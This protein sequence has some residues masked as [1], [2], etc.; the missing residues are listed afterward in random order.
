MRIVLLHSPLVGPTTWTAVA[1]LL[2]HTGYQVVVPDLRVAVTGR[3][4]YQPAIWR[5]VTD[6]LDRA[7]DGGS[8]VLVG[9]SGAGQLLPAIASACEAAV[10]ALVFVDAGMPQPGT[11]WFQRVPDDLAEHIR[12]L[13]IGGSLPS[14]DQWFE[15]GAIESL[16]PEP[17]AR[18]QFRQDLPRVPLTFLAEPTPLASWHGPCGYLLLSEAYRSDAEEAHRDGWPVVEYQS[19]HLAMLT[20]PA[21]VADRL[22]GLIS[23]LLDRGRPGQER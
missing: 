15:P 23:S 9:H 7:N 16:L 10:P 20:E 1:S 4:P 17:T 2:R 14:W 22:H 5:A 19:H 8:L 18:A 21:E 13:V 6:A 11:S 12:R 3:P